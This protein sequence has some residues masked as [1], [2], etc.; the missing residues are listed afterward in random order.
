M[1]K[2]IPIQ[3]EKDSEKP[4]YLQISKQIADLIEAGSLIDGQR[5][6]AIRKLAD[7]LQVNSITVVKAYQHLVQYGYAL[8]KAG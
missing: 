3:L 8:S 4:L 1:A 2:I 6:P 5:L 7:Q